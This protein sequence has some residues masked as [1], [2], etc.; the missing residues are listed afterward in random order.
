MKRIRNFFLDLDS[1]FDS[2]LF[3]SGRGLRE[4]WERYSA[5]MDNFYVG[6]WRRWVFIEP[7]SEMATLGLAG[8]LAKGKLEPKTMTENS[9]SASPARCLPAESDMRLTLQ[10]RC[11]GADGTVTLPCAY[12]A[13]LGFF[14]VPQ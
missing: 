8:G 1:R 3:S 13:A 10:G 12:S 11:R 14:W 5:F 6:R 4:L 7:L 2:T 9:I